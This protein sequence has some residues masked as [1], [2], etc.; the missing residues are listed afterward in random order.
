MPAGAVNCTRPTIWGN[1]FVHPDPAEAVAAYLR[2]VSGGMQSF[3]I[4]PGGLQFAKR[5]HR[6]CLHHAYG[7][8]VRETAPKL[9]RG[10]TLLCWCALDA[11]CHVTDVLLPLANA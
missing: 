4:A 11:P 6:N 9:L 8:F 1:P 2:L 5:F 3:S 7:E 10:R